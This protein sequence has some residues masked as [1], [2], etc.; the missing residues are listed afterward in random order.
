[1]EGSEEIVAMKA[2]C[3]DAAE[4]AGV[5]LAFSG[6]APGQQTLFMARIVTPSGIT[7]CVAVQWLEPD[8]KSEL[9]KR[10]RAMMEEVW[11]QQSKG[12]S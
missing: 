4:F 1:M 8:W 7:G 11:N 10:W 12:K 3:A 6:I 2:F 5:L 9:R